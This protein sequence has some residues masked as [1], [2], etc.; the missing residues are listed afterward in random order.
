MEKIIP[1]ELPECQEVRVRIQADRKKERK[2]WKMNVLIILCY[3]MLC[4]S[5]ISIK[6]VPPTL[7]VP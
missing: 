4:K 3:V 7:A 6:M 1:E 5:K 2:R